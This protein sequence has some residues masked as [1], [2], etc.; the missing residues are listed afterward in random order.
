MPRRLAGRRY[1]DLG[2]SRVRTRIPT[3]RR[4]GKWVSLREI[5]RFRVP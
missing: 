4:L 5:L 3:T 1:A 2:P